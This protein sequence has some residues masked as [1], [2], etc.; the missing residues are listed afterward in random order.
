MY[1]RLAGMGM[2]YAGAWVAN[3]LNFRFMEHGLGDSESTTFWY[4]TSF[5]NAAA[6]IA[7]YFMSQSRRIS[8]RHFANVASTFQV[9]GGLGIAAGSARW[10]ETG[11]GFLVRVGEALGIEAGEIL[12]RLVMPIDDIGLRLLYLDGVTWV[13][14]WLF[15]FPLLLPMPMR[16]TLITIFLTASVVPAVLGI[17]AIVT[18]VP[19]ILRPWALPYAAEATVGT[20]ICAGIAAY[21]AHVVYR[22]TRDLSAARR[23]GSYE[24]VQRIGKGG[25]GEVWRARHQML[26]RPAAIKLIRPEVLGGDTSTARTALK[27][28]ER[29][30]QL[31]TTLT[32]PNT[33]TIFDYGRTPDGDFYCVMELLDG[34]DL[35]TFVSRF[36]PAPAGRV[37]RW[38]H[39]ACE[40]LAEAHAHGLIHR[41]I[42]PANLFTCRYG[43]QTDFLKV[44]DFGLV[45][46]ESGHDPG[47]TRMTMDQGTTGT[48]AYIPPELALGEEADARS[49]LYSLGC[50][51]YWL[52]TGQTVFEGTTPMQLVV[53][54]AKEE[55]VLPS[56]RSELEIPGDLEA[57]VMECL[58]KDRA[59]RPASA[60][61]LADRLAG[62]GEFEEWSAVASDRWWQTHLPGGAE[63]P[64]SRRLE[65]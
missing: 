63:M 47:A 29:E 31:T 4:V 10:L 27:R 26:A 46:G 23:M 25:M 3:F 50:V 48:P 24:L 17:S 28:F 45:K 44:L 35:E 15:A 57:I 18:G 40:S 64:E 11:E 9:L 33:I 32:H 60:I 12:T 55:P 30:V 2:V 61:E 54:H 8:P 39:Q 36:G 19:E 58:S 22:L 42:K 16:R 65:P 21:G 14:V 62:C 43:M 5:I 41:D 56:L 49:D 34:I 6:G 52:L 51:A 37:L 20:F 53:Q 13:A 1:R 7:I 59:S 38:L